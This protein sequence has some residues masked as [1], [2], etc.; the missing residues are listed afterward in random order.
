VPRHFQDGPNGSVARRVLPRRAT[1]SRHRRTRETVLALLAVLVGIALIAY[2]YVSDY[3]DVV[4]QSKVQTRQQDAV[5][6]ASSEDL[7]TEREQAEDFDE[8]IRTSRIHV[9]DPFD[10]DSGSP[11]DEEYESVL[12]L[13]GDGVMGQ[14]VIPCIGVNLPIYHGVDGDGMNH[15]VGHMPSTSLP[16]GGDS[17]HC[18][19]AG[20][21]GLPSARIFDRLTELKVGDWFVIRIL[22]R[23]SRLSGHVDRGGPPRPDGRSGHPR[24]QGSRHLGHLYALWHQHPAAARACRAL[25]RAAGVAGYAGE[26]WYQHVGEH[27]G[28]PV[29]GTAHARRYR[30]SVPLSP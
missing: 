11:S 9:T 16:I 24:R 6:S 8:R 25:R 18:V 29:D 27:Y 2:P 14:L 19:L 20:H 4:E 26:Q 30:S 13:V 21:T 28:G 3:L 23:G 10:P 12:N 7:S 15:G 22:G 17:T 1:D 5:T